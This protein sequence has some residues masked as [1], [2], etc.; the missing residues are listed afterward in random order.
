MRHLAAISPHLNALAL[1]DGV[2]TSS[3]LVPSTFSP[4]VLPS[5]KSYCAHHCREEPE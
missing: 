2:K 5:K 4:S 1:T 3:H